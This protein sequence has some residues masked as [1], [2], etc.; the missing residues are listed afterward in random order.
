MTNENIESLHA[1]I[2]SFLEDGVYPIYTSGSIS[3]H[4]LQVYRESEGSNIR[5]SILPI[6][7]RVKEESNWNAQ[8]VMEYQR[9]YEFVPSYYHQQLEAYLK[10]ASFRELSSLQMKSF[11]SQESFISDKEGGDCTAWGDH[12]NDMHPLQLYQEAFKEVLGINLD[13]INSYPSKS[14]D[15]D[16]EAVENDPL[17][18]FS[19]QLLPASERFR[20]RFKAGEG[21]RL[22]GLYNNDSEFYSEYMRL[23]I[24]AYSIGLVSIRGVSPWT[25]VQKLAINHDSIMRLID[26]DVPLSCPPEDKIMNLFESSLRFE[27]ELFPEWAG[28]K[29]VMEH[30]LQGFTQYVEENKFCD[31]DVKNML[32]NPRVRDFIRRLSNEPVGTKM[33]PNST[34]EKYDV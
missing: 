18:A 8:V 29:F 3:H 7:H 6:V 25:M 12:S 17:Y 26:G 4:V 13:L 24:A 1:N 16:K 15:L 27:R 2:T 19:Q 22:P 31:W 5:N 34:A 33:P 28:D 30:H 10:G 32:T 21:T 14:I 11:L 9:Y 23:S 20:K